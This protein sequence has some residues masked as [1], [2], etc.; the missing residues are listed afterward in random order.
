LETEL[1]DTLED[2]EW[3]RLEGLMLGVLNQRYGWPD[4]RHHN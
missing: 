2:G 1:R 4:Y 3:G